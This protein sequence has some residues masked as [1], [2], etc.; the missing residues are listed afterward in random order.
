MPTQGNEDVIIKARL[1]ADTS[2][3]EQSFD[4]T[5]SKMKGMGDETNAT[6]GH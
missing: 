2:S 1:E 4:K 6:K 5:K 3:A